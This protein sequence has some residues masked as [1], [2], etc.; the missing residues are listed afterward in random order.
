VRT[1]LLA[2]AVVLLALATG[3]GDESVPASDAGH[4]TPAPSPS[5]PATPDATASRSTQ[6]ADLARAYRAFA[7]GGPLPSVA[8]EVQLYLGNALTGVVT[9]AQARTRSRWA[10]C[11]EVGSYA[12]ATCPLSPLTALR[13]SSA[14][15]YTDRPQG[16]CLATY[17]PVPP[18]LRELTRTTIVPRRGS[19]DT[20]AKNFAIQ[21]FT[22]DDDRLVAVSTLLGEP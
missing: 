16:L 8:E 13:R 15:L 7:R 10:T 11:T 3:C 17:G 21:L 5:H 22:D 2:I 12:G 4:G 18:N 20:C 14:V 9:R 19:I 1:R 6:S